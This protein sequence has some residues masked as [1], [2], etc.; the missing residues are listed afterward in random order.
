MN[1]GAGKLVLVVDDHADFSVALRELLLALG[2]RVTCASDGIEALQVL[3]RQSVSLVLTDL[4]M[5]R[6]DGVE[7]IQ[8]LA[9]SGGP[10]P[11]SIAI[12][13]DEHTASQSVKNTARALGAKA[14]LLKPFSKD[15]LAQAIDYVFGQT[16]Q[17]VSG[18][19]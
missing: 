17:A 3:A 15:Q 11:P 12:T 7:L 14:A 4:Y 1:A 2:F 8:Q 6:M 13:G 16:E 10:V 5:P 19:V 18:S 9:I